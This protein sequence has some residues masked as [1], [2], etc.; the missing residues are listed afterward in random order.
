MEF[1]KEKLKALWND[2]TDKA[3]SAAKTAANKAGDVAESAKL[4]ITL[5]S[6]Q[7]KLNGMFSTLGQAYYES[8]NGADNAELLA[9]QIM[10]IDEQKRVIAELKALIAE[11]NGKMFCPSC[12]KELNIE[13]AF[14]SACGAK[15][16]PKNAPSNDEE[17]PAKEEPKNEPKEEPAKSAKPLTAN[18]FIDAFKDIVN[19]YYNA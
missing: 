1:N 2:I 19:K 18:E 3:S 9:A 4:S 10:E 11:N 13:D 6:E 16:E 12:G 7:S 17:E 8:K 14:C 5:K 15:Q